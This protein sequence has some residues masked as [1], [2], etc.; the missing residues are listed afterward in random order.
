[1]SIETICN[2]IAKKI[3][4]VK[5]KGYDEGFAAGQ[6]SGGGDMSAWWDA[7]QQNGLRTNYAY[8][9]SYSGW[10]DDTFFPKYNIDTD[11]TAS[12]MFNY[13]K[14]TDIQGRL[15]EC[16]VTI[17]THRNTDLNNFFN[18]A[19]KLTRGITLDMS[20]ATSASALCRS[21]VNLVSAPLK[22]IG[23]V[24]NWSKAFEGCTALTDIGQA[25][26]EDFS[27]FGYFSASVD[28][29]HTAID[30]GTDKMSLL[31]YMSSGVEKQSK[32]YLKINPSGSAV[33]TLSDSQIAAAQGHL[34]TITGGI[35]SF[36]SLVTGMGWTLATPD[37]VVA[38]PANE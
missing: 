13:T 9:F 35:G 31:L 30:F 37:G 20:S 33:L 22:H 12:C 32:S 19:T 5:Q 34:D 2:D 29:S 18:G 36:G 38:N 26:G 1:M 28:L 27:N 15:D 23:G 17:T 24:T 10:N 25:E 6:A 16:G 14:I 7:Y 3:G 4:A 21:C 11:G 8:A